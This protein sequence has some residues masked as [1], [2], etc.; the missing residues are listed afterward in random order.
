[1][2]YGRA[3]IRRAIRTAVAAERA[4]CGDLADKLARCYRVVIQ[5]GNN[6]SCTSGVMEDVERLAK[7]IKEPRE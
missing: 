4:R 5:M 6:P 7:N 1:L 3:A 2:P